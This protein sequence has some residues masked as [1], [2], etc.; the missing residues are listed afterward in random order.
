M[1]E[2]IQTIVF[3][4]DGTIYQNTVFH[5]DYLRFLVEGTGKADWAD[6]LIAFADAVFRGERL[7]MNAFYDDAKIV[8]GTP[9]TYFEALERALLPQLTYEEALDRAGCIY[10]GDAWAVVT[11]M[12]KTLGL[13][14]D[15]RGDTVYRRTRDK[16][17]ADG[18][19]GCERLRS[20]IQGLDGDFRAIL[21]TNSYESTAVDF[22]RQLG[23]LNTF[24]EIVFSANKPAG[25][26]DALRRRDA[27][28]L[29]HPERVLTVGDHAFNDLMPLQRL[30]CRSLWIN[31]FDNIHT[32][33]V[34]MTVRT[35]EELAGF[36]EGLCRGERQ[37]CS[38]LS[39]NK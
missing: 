36:L 33:A 21:L 11:L 15:G 2:D 22:L 16:M 34:D 18:M 8:A 23:F 35:P 5:R 37:G 17:N 20:A 38:V 39:P 31:P 9:E 14:E 24:P 13:L 12:G 10:T 1:R 7:V 32:P 28:L 4:L 26:I 29:E 30:G 6:S 25:M 19:R 3:D 27:A